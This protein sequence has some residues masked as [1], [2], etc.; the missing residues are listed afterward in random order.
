MAA[1]ELI[2]DDDQVIV[3][4]PSA[5][6]FMHQG[7]RT[8][9]ARPVAQKHLTLRRTFIPILLTAGFLLFVLGVLR[10]VWQDNNPL[11]GLQPW[12][13]A[14]MFLFALALWALAALNVLAVKHQLQSQR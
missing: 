7:A 10:F 6:V 13:V 14:L 1:P 4:A 12:L 2:D 3:P 8:A 5:D 9:N 11:L